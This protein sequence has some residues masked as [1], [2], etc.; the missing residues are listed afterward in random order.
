MGLTS[1]IAPDLRALLAAHGLFV[2]GP[3]Q[4]DTDPYIRVCKDDGRPDGLQ[5]GHVMEAIGGQGF[6]AFV[7]LSVFGQELGIF[8][9]Q[10]LAIRAIFDA[11]T[12]PR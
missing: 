3:V 10:D 8:P 4:G 6:E 11:Y 5:I 7:R 12:A 1:N 9:R 2:Q